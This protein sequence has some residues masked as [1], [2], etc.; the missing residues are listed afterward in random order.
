MQAPGVDPD[1]PGGS[2][3]AAGLAEGPGASRAAAIPE[4]L[5][6]LEVGGGGWEFLVLGFSVL[7]APLWKIVWENGF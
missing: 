3:A 1:Q 6:G 4:A 5:G 7:F 2:R